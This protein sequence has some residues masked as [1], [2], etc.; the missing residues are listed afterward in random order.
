MPNYDEKTGIHYGAISMHDVSQA[1]CDSSDYDIPDEFCNEDGELVS[2][3]EP[4]NSDFYVKTDE[5]HAIGILDTDILICKSP[6]FTYCKEC[7]PCVP[8]AGDLNAYHEDG[9]KTYCF[10]KDWFED[11]NCPYPYYDV[12]TNALVYQPG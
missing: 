7:S 6:Y 10:A 8:N 3:Y 1:W 5:Y 4:S 11:E 9:R 12:N 2:E